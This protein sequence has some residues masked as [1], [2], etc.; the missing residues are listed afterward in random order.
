MKPLARILQ[1][2]PINDIWVEDIDKD[3][4]LDALLVG[5][6][7]A[8][9]VKTGRYDAFTGAFLKGNG[10]GEFEVL[11]GGESGFLADKDARKLIRHV[12]AE[13]NTAIYVVAN[14]ADSLQLF[15]HTAN[16]NNGY[17]HE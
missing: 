13:E 6:S 16:S 14:N 15:Y 2:A 17:N 4:A 9:E 12:K 8:T 1:T 11:R 5:N 10:K 7:Y 3:G